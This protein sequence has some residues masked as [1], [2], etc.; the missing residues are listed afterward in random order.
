[1]KKANVLF[2]CVI[3]FVIVF[4]LLD[5]FNFKSLEEWILMPVVPVFAVLYFVKNKVKSSR[6]S[7]F[8]IAYSLGAAIQPLDLETYP[9]LMY[10]LG[11]GLYMLAYI[12]LLL[13][14]LKT[15]S[16]KV[17]IKK[18]RS[19]LLILIALN[20]YLIYN[21]TTSIIPAIFSEKYGSGV[22]MMEII[23]NVLLLLILSLAL[24]NYLE[25]EN[26]KTLILFIG[27]SF[28]VVSEFLLLGYYYLLESYF[29]NYFSSILYVV[30]FS[31]LY[32]QSDLKFDIEKK[33]VSV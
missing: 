4:L 25:N 12:F 29:L 8:L 5:Q 23:Y 26:K 14:L 31:L 9:S 18:L 20:V 17:V 27:C 19:Q 22:F 15:M 13:E 24:L 1:M 11:N 2:V 32:F 30:A 10:Y 21:L 16:F 28:I 33:G 7:V 3:V 6:F